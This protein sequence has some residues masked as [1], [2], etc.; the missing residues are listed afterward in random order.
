[1][2]I[3]HIS[4]T[5]IATDSRILKELAALRSSGWEVLG[6]GV[7]LEG[8]PQKSAST[9]VLDIWS[10]Q[11]KMKKFD[12][13]WPLLNHIFRFLELSIRLS[14]RA[15]KY[16][17]AIIHCHDVYL[18]P[19]AVALKIITG[20][21]LIY[22]AHELESN[23]TGLSRCYQ[24][25]VL[26]VEKASW[27]FI[28][29]LITVSHAIEHWYIEN[30]GSKKSIVILNSPLGIPD[31]KSATE[32]N[33]RVTF[34]IPKTIP[35]FISVGQLSSGRGIDITLKAFSSIPEEAAVVFMGYGEK[36][37]EIKKYSNLF[38][39]IFFHPAVPHDEV[40]SVCSSCD[41]GI[42]LIENVSLSYFFCLP[43]KLFEYC[44]AE[45]PVIG[46]NF[47]EISRVIEKYRLGVTT[48]VS[49]RPLVD[50][51][52]EMILALD[53][54]DVRRDSLTDLCWETQADKLIAMY[55]EI[56]SNI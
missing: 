55:H 27:P 40:V 5:D 13:L 52:R 18:L 39:N 34:N 9:A 16:K 2:K 7:S 8:G 26:W 6:L 36:V 3:L 24:T 48:E 21:F 44:F 33:V 10:Y 54:F 29:R 15:V 35:V 12:L 37:D 30:L 51:V 11:L 1:M 25:L 42:A 53:N 28:D 31:F 32:K 14:W 45:I 38:P 41:C 20:A 46:S 4:H 22:D 43:N 49:M 47:P 19:I 23:R 17:P 50:A 56:E